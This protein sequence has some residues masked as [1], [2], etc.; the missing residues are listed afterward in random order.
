[1]SFHLLWHDES[2]PEELASLKK[3]F[4]VLFAFLDRVYK[5][6][7]RKRALL[8]ADDINHNRYVEIGVASADI[9]TYQAGKSHEISMMLGRL[10]DSV[11]DLEEQLC[12]KKLRDLFLLVHDETKRLDDSLPA[13]NTVVK[14][15]EQFFRDHSKL[16]SK[17]ELRELRSL[18]RREGELLFTLKTE[19][20]QQ[21]RDEL[22]NHIQAISD[23]YEAERVES[24]HLNQRVIDT[25]SDE[26]LRSRGAAVL[27]IIVDIKTKEVLPMPPKQQHCQAAAQRAGVSEQ[28]L[29]MDNA[30]HLIGGVITIQQDNGEALV[31]GGVGATGL[32]TQ[33]GLR[34]SIADLKEAERLLWKY[35]TPFGGHL[36]VRLMGVPA[37]R[38]DDT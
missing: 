20:N 23:A 24:D 33:A 17:Q 12:E 1:M 28:E 38:I 10:V 26:D 36:E 7:T 11:E 2:L 19:T 25:Y 13:W 22:V 3:K 31:E 8:E 27:K 14:K 32:V 35:L 4:E 15:Q 18:V 16:Q 34:Y 6:F 9:L 21:R 5:Q 29:T 37:A 30:Q